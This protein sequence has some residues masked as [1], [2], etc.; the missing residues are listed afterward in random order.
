ME[1]GDSVSRFCGGID[2]EGVKLNSMQGCF[3]QWRSEDERQSQFREPQ[4][5]HSTG[6]VA[7]RVSVHTLL[8]WPQLTGLGAACTLHGRS[9]RRRDDSTSY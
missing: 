9:A 3:C 6:T 5:L 2:C 7:H 8:Q 4:S 1:L